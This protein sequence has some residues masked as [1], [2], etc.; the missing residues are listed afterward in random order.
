MRIPLGIFRHYKIDKIQHVSFAYSKHLAS[1]ITV[2]SFLI[3]EKK[4]EVISHLFNE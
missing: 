4:S 2:Y 3:F 1:K